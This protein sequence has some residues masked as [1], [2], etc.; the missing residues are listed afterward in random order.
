MCCPHFFFSVHNIF[1]FI[2]S[3]TKKCYGHS[4]NNIHKFLKIS[5]SCQTL[6]CRSINNSAMFKKVRWH[7][8]TQHYYLPFV[9][10]RPSLP[11]GHKQSP[12]TWSHSAACAQKHSSLQFTPYLPDLHASIQIHYIVIFTTQYTTTKEYTERLCTLNSQRVQ[13]KS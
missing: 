9:Q 8:N 10:W 6:L 12:V 3:Q 5:R 13:N 2:S 1:Y 4:L 7:E 11:S